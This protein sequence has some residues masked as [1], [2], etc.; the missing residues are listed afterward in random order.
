MQVEE[1]LW[2]KIVMQQDDNG[3]TPT[4]DFI[5]FDSNT[6]TNEIFRTEYKRDSVEGFL[7]RL[8]SA[9]TYPDSMSREFEYKIDRATRLL[10][11]NDGNTL[12]AAL[13]PSNFPSAFK[14]VGML[15]SSLNFDK[16]DIKDFVHLLNLD[17]KGW[18]QALLTYKPTKST[19]DGSP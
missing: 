10:M 14:L 12:G 9:C 13:M 2:A 17:D 3:S 4:K 11:I 1:V 18:E 6:V 16:I 5:V 7:S 19:S 15:R 8:D